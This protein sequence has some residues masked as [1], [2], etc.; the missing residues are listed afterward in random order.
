MMHCERPSE[1]AIS[2]H[3]PPFLIQGVLRPCTSDAITPTI[4]FKFPSL[5]LPR[6]MWMGVRVQG[7]GK[8]RYVSFQTKKRCDN[9]SR[10]TFDLCIN[11][12][13]RP[14]SSQAWRAT[15]DPAVLL[16]GVCIRTYCH[17][18]IPTGRYHC[19]C[20]QKYHQSNSSNRQPEYGTVHKRHLR[21]N[22]PYVSLY[23]I[24]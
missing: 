6:D 8:S 15:K 22:H 17:R 18:L 20:V 9:S 19:G 5:N 2:N 21:V 7:H 14:R 24:L 23:I 11:Q 3:N 13:Y 1:V 4:Q 10:F 12:V 16:F